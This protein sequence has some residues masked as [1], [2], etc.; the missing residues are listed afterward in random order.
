MQLWLVDGGPQKKKLHAASH[1]KTFIFVCFFIHFFHKILEED[2]LLK[3]SNKITIFHFYNWPTFLC[4]LYDDTYNTR[5]KSIA[6]AHEQLGLYT[7][8]NVR[9]EPFKTY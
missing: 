2:K 4:N 1:Y 8:C 3:F 9:T 6:L 7:K 5:G